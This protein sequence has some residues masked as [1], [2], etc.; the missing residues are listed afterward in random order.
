[1]KAEKIVTAT[2][3]IEVNIEVATNNQ[4]RYTE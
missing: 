2:T 3:V 1:M 4:K